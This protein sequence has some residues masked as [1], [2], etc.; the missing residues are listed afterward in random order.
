[1]EMLQMAIFEPRFA[2]MDETDSGLDI[3]ALKM[4]GDVV[5]TLRGPDRGFL[6]I[7]HYQRLLDYI[8]PDRVHVLAGG[9]IVKSGGADLAAELEKSGYDQFVEAREWEK[10][11]TRWLVQ[12]VT[13]LNT[14]LDDWAPGYGAT[15]DV[16]LFSSTREGSTGDHLDPKGIPFSDIWESKVDAKGDWKVPVPLETTAEI[17]TDIHEGTPTLIGSR[18]KDVMYFTRCPHVKKENIGC[19]IWK[20]A[21]KG[22][23]WGAPEMIMGLKDTVMY[24]VGH[25][26]LSHDGKVMVFASDIPADGHQGGKDLWITH[27]NRREKAWDPPINLGPEINSSDNESFPYIRKDGNLFYSSNGHVTMGGLD[28][29]IAEKSADEW[30]WGSPKNMQYPINSHGDDFGIV[31]EVDAKTRKDLDRGYF[32]TNRNREKRTD[33]WS[34]R[35]KPLEHM[36]EVIVIDA[37]KKTPVPGATV[38]VKGGGKSYQLTTGKD[39]TVLYEKIDANL[40]YILE[41]STYDIN[42]VAENYLLGK[43]KITTVGLKENTKFVKQFELK[44]TSPEIEIKFPEVRYELDKYDLMVIQDSINSQDSL[45][46]LYQTLVDNPTII[47][48]LQAHTDFRG[49]DSYNERLSQNRA[50]ACVDYLVTKGIPAERMVPKGYGEKRPYRKSL[51]NGEML[52]LSEKYITKLPTKLEQEQAHQMNRRTTFTVISWD[53]VPK[54]G[55]PGYDSGEEEGTGETQ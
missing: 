15:N 49:S 23:N 50:K 36:L 44:F 8:K 21:K 35:L 16:I 14:V 42:A 18:K 4:V 11:P 5:N 43:D 52:E 38:T 45:N 39:G 41:E 48:Q 24:T 30:K 32:T 3:D 25:P 26:A 2:I 28:I 51:A 22:R 54:P 10:S 7:T 37:D 27:Y 47:I 20:V 19:D 55:D 29:F 40:R 33:I 53:Y 31:F 13:Q 12:E 46:F 9:R 1:M 6:I 34:F 17:N